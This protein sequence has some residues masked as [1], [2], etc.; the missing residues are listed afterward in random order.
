ML[1]DHFVIH[2]SNE[3]LLHRSAAKSI[4][5]L[6]HRLRSD[7]VLSLTSHVNVGS[8]LHAVLDIPLHFEPPEYR[9][10]GGFLHEMTLDQRP[11]YLL[12]CCFPAF[13]EDAHHELFKI[14]EGF[15]CSKHCSATNC[16]A[17]RRSLQT[18]IARRYFLA[19]RLASSAR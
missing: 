15:P 13:P 11:T 7:T 3:Q 14:A 17:T 4:N 19:S 18:G 9:S 12:R 6:P 16:S 1:I 5:D 10:R 8:S 2:Q